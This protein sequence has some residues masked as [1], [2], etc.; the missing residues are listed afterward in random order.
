MSSIRVF[1]LVCMSL[2]FLWISFAAFSAEDF[3]TQFQS[4]QAKI[5]TAAKKSYYQKTYN[6]LSLLA[7]RNRNDVEQV[8]IY[9]AL[10]EYIKI[11]IKNIWSGSSSSSV[12]SSS[13]PSISS[14]VASWMTIPN[15]DMNRVRDVWLALHN[16]ERATKWLTPFTYSPALEWTASTWANHLAT[17][18]KVTNLH[19]RNSNVPLYSYTIIKQWFMDQ[20]IVFAAKEKNGQTLFTENLSYWYYTCN[21]VDCTD[22][23]IKAIK[24]TWKSWRS[25]FMSEKWRSYRPHYNAIV[26]NFANVG[27]WVSLVGKKYYLVSHYTQV[28]K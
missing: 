13:V 18:G 19:Q 12:A 27:L 11:Q 8:K 25:F 24:G 1:L 21:K 7:I 15:V 22:D 5:P 6:T 16:A 3:I 20:G 28:L 23:F 10:R 26:G 17:L 2:S 9:N 14:S 4:Q